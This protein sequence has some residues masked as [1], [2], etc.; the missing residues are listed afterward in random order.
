V[1]HLILW[2][3]AIL[4]VALISTVA[5]FAIARHRL[6]NLRESPIGRSI[7]SHARRILHGTAD[8]NVP[9]SHS[10]FA[11]SQITGSAL[12]KLPGADHFMPITQYKR[13]QFLQ[14][15]FLAKHARA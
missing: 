7:K 11:H 5:M 10:E 9:I 14:D 8:A 13:L 15:E 2:T 1:I 4:L 12:E 6:F 3:G